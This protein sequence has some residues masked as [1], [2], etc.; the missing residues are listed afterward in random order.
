MSDA[1]SKTSP[2][3]RPAR[4][5]FPRIMQGL[6][7]ALG[8]AKENPAGQ[9]AGLRPNPGPHQQKDANA[10]VAPVLVKPNTLAAVP[11]IFPV[12]APDLRAVLSE[13]R[14]AIGPALAQVI[15]DD[16]HYEGQRPVHPHH[17]TLLAEDMRRDRWT[18]GS[19]LCFGRLHNQI[20]LI[21][22]RHRM[23]A[24]VQA[25]REIE[26]QILVLDVASPEQLAALYYR[27][28]RRQRGRSDA[29]VLSALGVA[30]AHHLTKRMTKTVFD[31]ALIIG[32]E[33]QRPNY[34]L[35]PVAVRSDDARLEAASSWWKFG[36]I[37]ERLI[38]A[39][40]GKIK[41]KLYLGQ[42]AAVAMVTIKHQPE[43]AEAFWG[44]LAKN[45]GLRRGDPRSTLIT[46]LLTRPANVGGK[47]AAAIVAAS[48]WGAFYEKREV[49]HLKVMEGSTVRIAGTPFDGR[50]R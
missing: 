41:S 40:P 8:H 26:F 13:G 48:A 31:G 28:D 22:G 50:R 14:V 34:Q 29:E 7:E 19:Q 11:P 35:D 30:E 37:Y 49:Q 43:K 42:V 46:D 3:A 20:Y 44:G 15:L 1:P 5:D 12:E 18:P 4:S 10:M 36:A 47:L 27:F 6:R 9:T 25:G 23:T 33:F 32:F 16:A 21:N 38:M 45:D 24:V 39:A 17:V 2:Q